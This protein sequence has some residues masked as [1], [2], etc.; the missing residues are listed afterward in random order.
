MDT[1]A[2]AYKGLENEFYIWLL[3][4]NTYIYDYIYSSDSYD[5]D[6]TYDAVKYT[7]YTK[8]QYKEF[9]MRLIFV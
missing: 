1:N 3:N 2:E 7:K 5:C 8:D 4:E 6:F 9:Y